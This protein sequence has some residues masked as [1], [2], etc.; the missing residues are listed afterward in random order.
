[1]GNLFNTFVHDPLYNL[2]VFLY[3]TVSFQDFGIAI[4]VT[5]ILIKLALIPLSRQQIESQKK[6]QDL[7]PKIKEIQE[8]YK[9]DKEKQSRELM[10]F[11]KNNKINPF[12]GCLPLIVQ[13]IFFI[14]LYQALMNISSNGFVANGDILYP[15]VHDPGQ[16]KDVFLGFLNLAQ[17]NVWLAALTA[18]AQYWQMKMMMAK[19]PIKKQDDKERSDGPDMAKM[20]NTQMLYIFPILTLWM[21]SGFASGLVLYWFVS[22]LF[23]IV[24]QQFLF[25]SEKTGKSKK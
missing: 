16:M 14:A 12:G 4:V 20:M 25:S 13:I 8:K 7:N 1:M 6:L 15:F 5:T 10:S 19:Q 2:L 18:G 17:P 11:Y 22:T 9:D 3:N 23:M 21:G 24:Q